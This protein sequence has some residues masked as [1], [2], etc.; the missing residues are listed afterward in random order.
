ME[1]AISL[2][3]IYQEKAA[4][5]YHSA[6]AA[7]NGDLVM[8]VQYQHVAKIHAAESRYWLFQIINQNNQRQSL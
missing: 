6:R 2:T 1:H 8:A 3:I 5:W 7:Q 4:K